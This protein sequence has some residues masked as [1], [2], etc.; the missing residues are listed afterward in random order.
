[1]AAVSGPGGGVRIRP[2]SRS[3][4]TGVEALLAAEALPVAGVAEWIEC[5]LVAEREG[6]VVGVAGLELYAEDALL[7]SVAVARSQRGLGLGGL[8]TERALEA[9]TDAGARR[10]FLL[11]TTAESF[12]PRWGFH[13]IERSAVPAALRESVE[14]QGACPATAAV[15]LR[16]L[17]LGLD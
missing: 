6:E 5:F 17:T 7:R 4:Q 1:M 3:D 15:M 16:N 8:L 12:F 10:I 14:F 11:T 13:R 2:A 9:A